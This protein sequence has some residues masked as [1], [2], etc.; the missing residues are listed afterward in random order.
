[1]FAKQARVWCSRP[2]DPTLSFE[3]NVRRSLPAFSLFCST[4]KNID[5]F[6]FEIAFPGAGSTVDSLASILNTLLRLL[7]DLDPSGGHCMR[8]SYAFK[9]GWVFAYGGEEFFITAFASCYGMDNARYGYGC[10]DHVF[11][12]FQVS[13]LGPSCDD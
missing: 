13:S 6:G 5:G 9:R 2:W 7:S 11:V 12:L 10:E 8:V 1:V 3:D 4:Q